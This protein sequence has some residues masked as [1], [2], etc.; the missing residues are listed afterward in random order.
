MRWIR[1]LGYI[2]AVLGTI[3]ASARTIVDWLGRLDFVVSHREELGGIGRAVEYLT[4]PTWWLP[5]CVLATGLMII[6]ADSR[7]RIKATANAPETPDVNLTI[8]CNLADLPNRCPREGQIASMRL[9]YSPGSEIAE[10]I[11]FITKHCRP[12]TDVE[13]FPDLKFPQVYRCEITNYGGEPLLQ[14]SLM[15]KIEYREMLEA[16]AGHRQAGGA[17]HSR[18]WPVLLPKI[19][20]GKSNAVVFYIYNQSRYFASVIPP[21]IASFIALNDRSRNHVSLLPIGMVAG[22]SFW[23]VERLHQL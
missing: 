14:V 6:W 11:G 4:A 21:D 3:W 20:P 9:F 1:A 16:A 5:W 2:I 12:G 18:E 22:M 10:P 8:E 13:W 15:F 23:P 7:R 17:A 19:D